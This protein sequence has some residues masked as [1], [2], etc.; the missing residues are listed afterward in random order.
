MIKKIVPF[1]MVAILFFATSCGISTTPQQRYAS[2]IQP[3]LELLI[4]WQNDFSSLETLLTEELDPATGITRLQMIELY[5]LATEYQITRDEYSQLGL[6]P[7]DALV[8]PSV[9]IS[10]DGQKILEIFSAATAVEEIQE[11]HQVVLD[12]VQTRI[13][14]ADEVS[15]SIKDMTSI[16]MSK[17]GALVACDPFDTSMQKLT[18]FVNENK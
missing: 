7:L 11:T 5:N 4:K 6:M 17:A 10:K 18:T 9:N 12:C 16:D 8:A 1:L 2:E 15:S 13:A 14:F 3:A